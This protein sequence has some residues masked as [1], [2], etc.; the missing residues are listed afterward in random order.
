MLGRQRCRSQQVT[1]LLQVRRNARSCSARS[2]WPILPTKARPAPDRPA[3]ARW[4]LPRSMAPPAAPPAVSAAWWQGTAA[5]GQ[6]GVQAA[7]AQLFDRVTGHTDRAASQSATAL[8]V[9]ACLGMPAQQQCSRTRPAPAAPMPA[10]SHPD[11]R[12]PV[13]RVTPGRRWSHAACDLAPLDLHLGQQAPQ[14]GPLGAQ[15]R[16]RRRSATAA[17]PC[18]AGS[19]R[20]RSICSTAD[21]DDAAAGHRRARSCRALGH[22]P[23]LLQHGVGLEQARR[24]CAA[25][26]S[27]SSCAITVST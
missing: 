6:F 21:G 18:E 17:R 26:C 4:P 1:R 10:A 16:L 22:R 8:Q 15:P 20:P 27:R 12:A 25:P 13:H 23:G 9:G 5:Q 19:S 7:Q 24:H 11:R 3:P 14:H 2:D